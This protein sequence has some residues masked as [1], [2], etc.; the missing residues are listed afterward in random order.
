MWP[1]KC[2]WL[3]VVKPLISHL[4]MQLNCWSLRCNWRITCRRCP[5]YIFILDLTHGFNGLGKD[6]CNSKVDHFLTHHVKQRSRV[7]ANIVSVKKYTDVAAISLH[8]C[9]YMKMTIAIRDEKQLVFVF[10]ASYIRS[11]MVRMYTSGLQGILMLFTFLWR[12]YR[13]LWTLTPMIVSD[14]AGKGVLCQRYAGLS[15]NTHK[16]MYSLGFYTL[17]TRT[18]CRPH[19]ELQYEIQQMKYLVVYH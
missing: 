15:R 11:L 4:S 5:K 19:S 12:I 17:V 18:L 13:S 9:I 2:F 10:G 6:N 14:R 8:Q 7:V 16:H 3:V 1:K